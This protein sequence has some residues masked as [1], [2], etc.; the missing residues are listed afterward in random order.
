M[1]CTL[2]V[3]PPL[4][5]YALQRRGVAFAMG[6]LLDYNV[7][8]VWVTKLMNAP[9]DLPPPSHNAVT[10]TQLGNADRRLCQELSERTRSGIQ[11]TPSGRPMDAVFA[12][13]TNAPEV[14][15]MLQPLPQGLLRMTRYHRRRRHTSSASG[16]H[17]GLAQRRVLSAPMFVC[18]RP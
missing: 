7:H 16:P 18:Q 13:R 17:V 3:P 8:C 12:T 15:A 6:N 14:L 11:A 9:L 10:L 5:H 2:N 4:S 1:Q